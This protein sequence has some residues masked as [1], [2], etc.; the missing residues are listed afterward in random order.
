MPTGARRA[1]DEP[2]SGFEW[3]EDLSVFARA[4]WFTEDELLPHVQRFQREHPEAFGRTLLA[5]EGA[6]AAVAFDLALRSPGQ[7]LGVLLVDSPLLLAGNERRL[8]LATALGLRVRVVLDPERPIAG[9]ASPGEYAEALRAWLAEEGEAGAVT[10]ALEP[11]P[12]RVLEREL[13][14]LAR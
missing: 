8:L 3:Y 9:W 11:E 14:A 10:I 7:W 12:A 1:A 2:G 5:G 4:P 13:A 6:G